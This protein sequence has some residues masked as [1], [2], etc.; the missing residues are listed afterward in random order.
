MESVQGTMRSLVQDMM[1]KHMYEGAIF[2]ANKLAVMS[3]Y[4]PK[5]AFLLANAFFVDNQYHRC[6]HLLESR[7][8]VE[9]DVRFRLLAARCLLATRD[10]DECIQ[11]L[12]GQDV[13]RADE[14]PYECE[15]VEDTKGS[16]LR[17]KSAICTMLGK[18]F[19]NLENFSKSVSWYKEAVVCDPYNAEAFTS[20]MLGNKLNEK[21]E[22]E[23]VEQVMA[24]LP[25]DA[26]WLKHMYMTMCQSRSPPVEKQIK[27]SLDRLDDKSTNT[28]SKRATRRSPRTG[29]VGVRSSSRQRKPSRFSGASQ[30]GSPST[31]ENN[32][33]N[34]SI[35]WTLGMDSD[36]VASRATMLMRDGKYN[37]AHILAKSAMDRDSYNT[38]LLPIYLSIA[39]Q[40]KKKNDIFILG[41]KLMARSPDSAEAWFAAGCYYYVT[42]QYSSA[43]QYFGKATTIEKLFAPAWIGFA[44]AFACMD[45][46]DQA[47]AA[48]RTAARLFPGLHEPILGMSLEYSKMNNMALAEKMCKIAY[49]KC[50]NDPALMHEMGTL[51]YKN[52]QFEEAASVLERTVAMLDERTSG[53][54]IGVEDLKEV[55]L[56]NLSHAYRKLSR[57][58]LAIHALERA[59]G[60]KPHQAGTHS[61]MAFIYQLTGQH[62]TAVEWYHKALSVKPEDSFATSMLEIALQDSSEQTVDLLASLTTTDDMET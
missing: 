42:R 15:G 57:Y 43:R 44:H 28:G 37:E 12:H 25:E 30:E 51:A 50:P 13:Q 60:I 40:L 5:D 46:T 22:G 29:K 61:A 26:G 49:N 48:Y 34:N 17:L 27:I 36:I 52:G 39:I 31:P 2:Y 3:N 35:V 41:H 56:V 58:D 32:G 20:L 14:L 11:M 47:M 18:A 38:R 8:L 33:S 55:S 59:L 9:V 53:G 23:F 4:A 21:E 45:E 62:N 1:A 19:E 7:G 54:N 10:W 16:K 24:M 6:L